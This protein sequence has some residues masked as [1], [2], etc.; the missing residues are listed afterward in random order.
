M[1]DYTKLRLSFLVVVFLL[2]LTTGMLLI[3]AAHAS[4]GPIV[5][6]GKVCYKYT[7]QADNV[8]K[9]IVICGRP[10]SLETDDSATLKL[11]DW[12]HHEIDYKVRTP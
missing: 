6:P 10:G 8:P 9:R 12:T 3:Q 4:G 7:T 2:I 11:T 5:S 1:S